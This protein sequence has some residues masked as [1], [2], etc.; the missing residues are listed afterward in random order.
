[1][2]RFTQK[3]TVDDERCRL[4]VEIC[5]PNQDSDLI[6]KDFEKFYIS[7]AIRMWYCGHL[8][9]SALALLGLLL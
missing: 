9:N 5:D 1:M 7:G 4:R 2:R 8:N 3:A 6:E